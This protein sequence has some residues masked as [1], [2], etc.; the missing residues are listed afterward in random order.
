MQQLENSNQL[1]ENTATG[2]GIGAGRSS[3]PI[4]FSMKTP[5]AYTL[6]AGLGAVLI[7]AVAWDMGKL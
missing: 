5:G 6:L 2:A 7:L 1:D 3:S 4:S